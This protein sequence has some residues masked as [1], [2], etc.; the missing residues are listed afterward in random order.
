[1]SYDFEYDQI[2]GSLQNM[3]RDRLNWI[4]ILVRV[5]TEIH[6][7]CVADQLPLPI[8]DWW[9]VEEGDCTMVLEE[10]ADPPPLKWSALIVRKRRIKH[11]KQT[12]QAVRDSHE[13]TA[14]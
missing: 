8:L 14:G 12:T 11:G 1:M 9:S 4:K 13:V 2:Q 6:D 3:L 5:F 7:Q 10:G